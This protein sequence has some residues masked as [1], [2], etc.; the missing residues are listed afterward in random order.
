ML[1]SEYYSRVSSKALELEGVGP[2]DEQ[3]IDRHR[4][5]YEIKK[6][7]ELNKRIAKIE[8]EKIK[9]VKKE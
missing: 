2:E 9:L 3:E 5:L 8:Q 1:E 6:L 4:H 7:E